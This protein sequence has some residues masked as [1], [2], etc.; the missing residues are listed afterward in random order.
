LFALAGMFV[1]GAAGL[2]LRANAT[3]GAATATTTYQVSRG[4]IVATVAGSGSVATDQ[5]ADLAFQTNGTVREVLVQ[6]GDVVTAGQALARLDDRLLQLQLEAAEANLTTA[7]AQL[8]A[9]QAG[10]TAAE[11]TAAQLAVVN[12]ELQLEQ[13]TEGPA[14]A[15]VA[16]ARASLTGAQAEL[17]ELK[18]GSD[19]VEVQKARDALEQ[20]KNSLWSQQLGR[21]AVCV[22]PGIPCDQAQATV[23]NGEI[24]VRQAQA[25]LDRLLAGPSATELQLAELAVRQASARMAELSAAPT[26]RELEAAELQ[27]ANAQARLAELTAGP[28]TIELAQARAAV[29]N[30]TLG[31]LQAETALEDATLRAPFAGLVT[32]VDLVAGSPTGS[33]AAAI[34]LVDRTALHVDL[35]LSENDVVAVRAGQPVTLTFDSLSGK[36]LAGS[37]DYVAPAAESSNGV[38]TYAVRVGLVSGAPE[39]RVGMTANVVIVTA[40]KHNVLLVPNTALLP[41]GSGQVVLLLSRA[42][43][44]G[45]DDTPGQDRAGA[46]VPRVAPG[47][48]P[49]AAGGTVGG[50]LVAGGAAQVPVDAGLTDGTY[51]EIVSG[52]QEGD[53]IDALATTGTTART[54]FVGGGI[55]L[56]FLGALR[57]GR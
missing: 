7:Q 28:N 15:D 38:V 26:A 52:L 13:L 54:G 24:A 37:V 2:Y 8:D 22:K 43:G 23:G 6:P 21:D 18:A 12:A 31:R 16:G 49:G 34:A 53:L 1:L 29:A 33:N 51:T 46:L 56:P 48:P 36:A 9:L 25:T 41:S 14:A 42:A 17:A 20:A 44:S 32:A 40:E 11:L 30:A 55:G 19:P 27:L 4:S 45:A 10:P 47:T 5:A 35:K 50:R 3:S 57:G 39:V